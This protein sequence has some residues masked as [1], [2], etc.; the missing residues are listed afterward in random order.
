MERYNKYILSVILVLLSAWGLYSCQ[1]YHDPKAVNDP[2]LT[3][4]YCNDI[5]AINYDWGFPG[6]PDNS[7]CYYAPDL[8]KGVY[9]LDDSVFLKTDN[10][11]VRADTF[12]MTIN[13]VSK[14]KMSL[15]GF[16][17]NGDSLML[18]ANISY[19]ATLDTTLIDSMTIMGQPLCTIGDTVN[20]TINMNRINDSI[21]YINFLVS[22]DTGVMTRHIGIAR[23]KYKN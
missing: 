8:F 10:I 7:I 22:S 3:N 20:G 1:K 6:R 2:R 4:P 5:A 15:F 14:T 9:E 18:T 17:G 11:F 19:L 23:L 16:C 12:E 21:L 13:R